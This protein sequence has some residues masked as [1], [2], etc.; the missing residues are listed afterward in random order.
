[1]IAF[2][3]HFAADDSLTFLAI[4]PSPSGHQEKTNYVSYADWDGIY[5]T[6]IFAMSLIF[7]ASMMARNASAHL[8]QYRTASVSTALYSYRKTALLYV[9]RTGEKTVT[10]Y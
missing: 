5:Q 10:W 1:M 4:E 2:A 9:F 7:S 6:I 8:A 3:S